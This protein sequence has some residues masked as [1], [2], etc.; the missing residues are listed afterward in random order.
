MVIMIP[1]TH[2]SLHI[3]SSFSMPRKFMC[4]DLG[5]FDVSYDL[6]NNNKFEIMGNLGHCSTPEMV[7]DNLY[8]LDIQNKL[9]F[10]RNF[11]KKQAV[12]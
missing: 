6:R 1:C 11:T 5:I 2:V 10:K 9:Y 4:G 7:V 3:V 12:R 8:D